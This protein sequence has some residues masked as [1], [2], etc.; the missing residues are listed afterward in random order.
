MKSSITA[1]QEK[2]SE[3]ST[4]SDAVEENADFHLPGTPIKRKTQLQ[5]KRPAVSLNLDPPQ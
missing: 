5:E 4:S 2:H 3:N 1:E